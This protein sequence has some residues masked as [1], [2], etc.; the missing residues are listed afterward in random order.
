[1]RTLEEQLREAQSDMAQL[2]RQASIRRRQSSADQ[3]VKE[4]NEQLRR[5]LEE[6]K[7]VRHTMSGATAGC[8]S[9]R[10]MVP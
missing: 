3:A 7:K 6:L 4:E 1:M 10:M 2:R 5:E 9:W 8:V